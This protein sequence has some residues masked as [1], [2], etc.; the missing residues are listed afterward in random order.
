MFGKD[1][2]RRGGLLTWVLVA[3]TPVLGWAADKSQFIRSTTVSGNLYEK[4]IVNSST[5]FYV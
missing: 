4:L 2:A 1:F 3:A 5:A